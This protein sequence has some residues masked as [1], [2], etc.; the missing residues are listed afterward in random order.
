MSEGKQYIPDQFAG[1]EFKSASVTQAKLATK[2]YKTA[3]S[4]PAA[5]DDTGLGYAAGTIWTNTSTGQIFICTADSAE[6]A[7]WKGQE[8]DDINA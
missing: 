1:R 2:F 6:N 8:G 4:N 7:T 5:T 3:S